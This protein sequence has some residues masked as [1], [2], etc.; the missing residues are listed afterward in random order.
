MNSTPLFAHKP[1][2]DTGDEGFSLRKFLITLRRRQRTFITTLV[3]VSAAS[4][5]WLTYQ[6]IAFPKYQGAFGLLVA[7]PM[8]PTSSSTTASSGDP[9]VN[10]QIGAV[11]LNQTSQD[12]PTLMRVLESP[13]V[14]EPVFTKLRSQFPGESLPDFRVEQYTANRDGRLSGA[15]ILNVRVTGDNPAVLSAT[16]DLARD[17]FL[18]WSL[19]Q[20]R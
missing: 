9:F 16:L 2:A 12:L 15:G 11:A 14:L 1:A 7:N 5:A 4:T 19:T 17:T 18:E 20:R 3:L 13:T 10:A 6:R 8:S